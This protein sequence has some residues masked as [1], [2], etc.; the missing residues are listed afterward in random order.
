MEFKKTREDS[1]LVTINGR[2]FLHEWIEVIVFVVEHSEELKLHE[3]IDLA[4]YH[5]QLES[6]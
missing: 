1:P 5:G 2:R 3:D 4:F 6:G